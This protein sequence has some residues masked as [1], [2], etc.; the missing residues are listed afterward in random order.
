MECSCISVDIDDFDDNLHYT[1]MK[2][3]ISPKEYKCNECHTI[4]PA[5]SKMEIIVQGFGDRKGSKYEFHRTCSDCLSMRVAL[6][7]DFYM[8]MIWDTL[9]EEIVETDGELSQTKIAGMTKPARDKVCAMLD[10]Y[11]KRNE[12]EE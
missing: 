12:D 5:N 7:C 10:D 2:E 3:V 1:K 11:F 4:I 6:F 9:W 8:G